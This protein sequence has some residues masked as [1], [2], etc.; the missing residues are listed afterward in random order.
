MT[1]YHQGTL[2]FESWTGRPTDFGGHWNYVAPNQSVAATAGVSILGKIP[3]RDS[4]ASAHQRQQGVR[5]MAVTLGQMGD[6]DSFARSRAIVVNDALRQATYVETGLPDP[7]AS[8]D[9]RFLQN[10]DLLAL[11]AIVVESQQLHTNR[12]LSDQAAIIVNSESELID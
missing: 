3:Q 5:R 8:L 2:T 9:V 4:Q 6:S 1:G 7:G 10:A 12:N 11:A